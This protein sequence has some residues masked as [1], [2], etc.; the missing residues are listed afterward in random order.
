[1]SEADI[2]Q[3]VL[4]KRNTLLEQIRSFRSSEENVYEN[5]VNSEY[6]EEE[7]N[8]NVY[9]NTSLYIDQEISLNKGEVY[10]KSMLNLEHKSY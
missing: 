5:V 4:E 3:P 9:L 10:N 1:M 7:N 8:E 6:I 2:Q